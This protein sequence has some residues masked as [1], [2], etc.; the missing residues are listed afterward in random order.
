MV[1]PKGANYSCVDTTV[2]IRLPSCQAEVSNLLKRQPE[3]KYGKFDINKK[4]NW[5]CLKY[6]TSLGYGHL[7]RYWLCVKYRGLYSPTSAS[8]SCVMRMLFGLMSRWT[9]Q[10]TLHSSCRYLSPRAAPT[11]IFCLADHS[12]GSLLWPTGIQSFMFRGCQ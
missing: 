3:K 12:R 7:T 11:A 1:L 6:K 5:G 10:P 9:M 8:K 2:S 4:S